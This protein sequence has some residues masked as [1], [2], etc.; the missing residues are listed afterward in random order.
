MSFTETG[1][2][3]NEPAAADSATPALRRT[4]KAKTRA[5]EKQEQQ[6]LAQRLAWDIEKVISEQPP[7]S[8]PADEAPDWAK[9]LQSPVKAVPGSWTALDKR[10]SAFCMGALGPV[11]PK[12]GQYVIDIRL[13]KDRA[14]QVALALEGLQTLLPFI[15]PIRGEYELRIKF[16]KAKYREKNW[17][18]VS[19]S[20]KVV[21][22]SNMQ[23]SVSFDDLASALAYISQ[24]LPATD[25]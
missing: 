25:A 10:L 17:M 22:Q 18:T 16:G 7:K 9:L 3:S 23:P 12:T 5:Q 4:I 21:I 6:Q 14:D 19:K 1:L 15:K 11:M 13:T 20:G 2:Q 8:T 24:H